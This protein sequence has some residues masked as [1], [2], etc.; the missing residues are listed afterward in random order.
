MDDLPPLPPGFRRITGQRKPKS[1][2]YWVQCRNGWID[3]QAPWP[4][5]GPRWKWGDKPDDWDAVA[6]K[7]A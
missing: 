1:G 6:V 3:H 4:A 7:N 2:K 5:D